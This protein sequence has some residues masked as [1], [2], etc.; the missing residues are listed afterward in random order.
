MCPKFTAKSRSMLGV[1]S[2]VRLRRR[3]E[4]RVLMTRFCGFLCDIDST[5]TSRI[6]VRLR[7]SGGVSGVLNNGEA[8]GV[9][10]EGAGSG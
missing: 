1:R 2:N 4:V 6:T 8:G 9:S 7:F 10:R 5:D 3:S